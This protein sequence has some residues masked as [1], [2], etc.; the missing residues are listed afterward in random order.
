[1]QR[2]KTTS[3][4]VGILKAAAAALLLLVAFS[5]AVHAQA[6]SLDKIDAI[7][8]DEIILHGEILA[9]IAY[10]EANGMQDD[11]S[12]YC[13]VMEEK[14][15]EKL[16]LNKARQDSIEVTD[17]QVE[18]ELE[19][20][21]AYFVQGYGGVKQ[22]EEIYGKPLIEIK[23]D[24]REEV[25][26]GLLVQ[27]MRQKIVTDVAVTPREVK[28]FYSE[29]PKDSMPLLPAEVELYHLA[30]MPKPSQANKDIAKNKLELIRQSIVDKTTSFEEMAKEHSRDYGSAK[31][32]G[33][34]G[35]FGRGKMVP[36]F[37]EMAFKTP[38]GD[39]SPIFESQ[40]GYH[41]MYVYDR[42]GEQVSA[43][44]ILVTP[45]VGREDDSTAVRKLRDILSWIKDDADTLTFMQAAM[46]YSDDLSTQ[47][48]GGAIKNPQTGEPRIPIDALDAELFFTVDNM[49]E[50]DMSEIEEWFT[51]DSKRGFHAVYLRK[52]YDP[53]I[54]NLK[55]D[56]AK[57]HQA[58][59]Q[60]KQAGALDRWFKRAVTNIYIDIKNEDCVGVLP[61]L[62]P[63]SSK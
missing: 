52:R 1:M 10:Y 30:I 36:E 50:G 46:K 45:D 25:K 60:A 13:R 39:V 38:V 61:Y 54:A 17:D 47:S 62:L 18:S 27:Q 5:P 20:K 42:V 12:M 35:T 56:Y 34:L 16:L 53:H 59:L 19:R 58:A 26:N 63:Y 55:E 29:I 33:D 2:P 11:G 31:I 7:V 43:K 28:K 57:L 21:V 6:Q 24:I 23:A 3:S 8:G 22:L 14:I 44:H 15:F 49:K 32:G 4:K 51:P 37:E 41:V 48:Y 40:F 9:Q